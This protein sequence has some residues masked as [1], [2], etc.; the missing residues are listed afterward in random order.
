MSID[1]T[2]SASARTNLSALQSTAQ[3][4]QVT[5]SHLSTGKAVNSAS[6][7]ATAYF[8]SQG[9]LQRANDL[10]NLK[11]SLA[12]S[13]QTVT[14][15]NQSIS[16]VT[17]VVQQLEGITTQAL[18]T[19]DATTRAGLASQF[20]SLLTQLDLLVND[21][22]FN[23]TNLLNSTGNTLVVY[24]NEKNTTALTITGVNITHAGL[25]ISSAAN[26]F[27]SNDNINTAGS[28]LLTALSTL[29]TDAA[30]F[31]GNAT[32]IQ[33]RQDFTSNL[34]NN[35]QNA[36]NNLILADTNTEGAN[37]Q[38]LQAQNSLGIISLGISGQL[39]QSI[40]RLF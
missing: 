30:N 17:S 10:S 28:L 5:Q 20:N 31:G 15:V 21:A 27:A 22:T 9:F 11:N 3:A 19:T 39:E 8:A 40:L 34:I 35:L 36:S 25:N 4:L 14:S 2:L 7:N 38:A 37:L 29:R 13:L 33:T 23:G 26:A 18:G 6:D 1:V 24:F 32:L 16:D 12:T